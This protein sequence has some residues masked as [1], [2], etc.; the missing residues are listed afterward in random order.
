[1]WVCMCSQLGK[2]R[3]I[4]NGGGKWMFEKALWTLSVKSVNKWHGEKGLYFFSKGIHFWDQEIQ[5]LDF[6]HPCFQY[7]DK[8]LLFLLHVHTF[9]VVIS[10]GRDTNFFTSAFLKSWSIC[11]LWLPQTVKASRPRVLSPFVEN[12]GLYENWVFSL[13][14]KFNEMGSLPFFA[15]FAKPTM[16]LLCRS[17]CN[18]FF[19]KPFVR[20]TLFLLSWKLPIF[21]CD[22]FVLMLRSHLA[23]FPLQIC[24]I[25]LS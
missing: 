2:G 13:A 7:A 16:Q 25:T 3:H 12:R 8:N 23:L 10:T 24:C 21:K 6:F 1:M 22:L 11:P 20:E 19:Q 18:L 15:L 9:I 5:G 4:N 17:E 14:H